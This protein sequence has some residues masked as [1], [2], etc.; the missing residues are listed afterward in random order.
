MPLDHPDEQVQARRDRSKAYLISGVLAL[1]LLSVDKALEC[2]GF[3]ETEEDMGFVED[4][5]TPKDLSIYVTLAVLAASNLAEAKK[6]VLSA[7]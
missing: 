1:R 2:F 6:L 7:H 3:V 5:T 4:F